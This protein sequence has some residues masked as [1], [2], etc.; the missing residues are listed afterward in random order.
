MPAELSATQERLWFLDQFADAPVSTVVWWARLGGA[1]DV[2]ALAGALGALVERHP[3]LRTVVVARDGRPVPVVSA[4]EAGALP[5]LDLS[6]S[7]EA[8]AVERA[9]REFAAEPFDLATGPLLRARLLRLGEDEHELLV[10]AHQIALDRAG[11]AGFGLALAE[12]FAGLPGGDGFAAFAAGERARLADPGLGDVTRSWRE[13][14]A[15]IPPL[16]LPTDRNRPSGAGYA[17]SLWTTAIDPELAEAVDAFAAAEGRSAGEVW[18]GAVQALL[19][20]YTG[21]E[22]LALGEAAGPDP[23]WS[24]TLGPVGNITVRRGLLGENA[25]FRALLDAEAAPPPLPFPTLV[26]ALDPPRDPSRSPIFQVLTGTHVTPDLSF[27]AARVT[28][29]GYG[30]SGASLYDLDWWLD[31]LGDARRLA[32][33]YRRDL[34]DEATVERMARHFLILLKAMLSGPDRA[35]AELPLLDAA[36]TRLVMEDFNATDVP[37]PDEVTVQELFEEQVL[38]SPDV[39]AVTYEGAHL[40]YAELNARANRI[41]HRLRAAGVGRGDF[42]GLCLERDLDFLP[43]V[44]GVLKSGG[45]YV[46]LDPAYPPER[47]DFMVADTGARYLITQER[48]LGVIPSPPPEIIVVDRDRAE[49]DACPD[50]DPDNVN[51]AGDL[52]YVVYTSGSTGRPKGVETIH[53]GVVGLVINTDILALDAETSYLQ[54]SPLSFDAST[55]EIFGPL[56]NG[57]RVVLLPSGVPTPARVARTVVE[58]GVNT[59]WLVAPLANLTIDTHLDRLHGL[60]QFMIGGDALSIPHV[61]KVRAAM[62]DVRLVNGYGPTEVTAFSVTLQI[63]QI[64]A[65]WPS[66]PIGR[67]M[68]N[69]TAYILDERMAPLPVGIW[70]ELYLGGPRVGLGYH[71]RPDLNAVHFLPDPFRPGP[72]SRIYRTGDRVRWLPDGT[73]QFH[74]RLDTQV[75]IDGLR[76]ELG[77][78]QSVIAGHES[79]GAVVVTA[80]AIGS[81]RT[82]VAYVVPAGPGAFDAAALRASLSR[83]LPSVMVPAHYI[84]LETIPLTPN[85]KVDYRAL[86]EPELGGER[87]F[88]APES[89]PEQVLAGIWRD[90]LGVERVGAGDNF[91]ALGGHS[92]RAVAMLAGLGQACGV[93][94]SVQD[95]FEAPVLAD[96]AARVEE[97]MIAALPDQ[98]LAELLTEVSGRPEN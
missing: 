3:V 66:V 30:H 36:E 98:E 69:T 58:Q 50:A 64:P 57:G 75:K 84:L 55:L 17:A 31:G 20:R 73:I 37:Y 7:S 26:E 51:E 12:A 10:G 25:G 89:F 62:P 49:I 67:P 5:L 61:R 59:L 21:Q 24:R 35:I 95:V 9:R 14:L 27:G 45:A 76:V 77:E 60:R 63:G 70:G 53:R 4:A 38:R 34:F 46:P 91:F 28:A 2:D 6:G 29:A 93:E 54:I 78:I 18:A 1:L 80:P 74:G 68:N 16:E 56:L 65:D 81:R 92:L 43:A 40:T 42:V 48:L 33:A 94:L 23:Q 88:V 22:L 85:N 82:L 96:L 86:P 79:V 47:L 52:T 97:R 15:G 87:E 71:H 19:H 83:H 39:R 90:I 72:E 11:L 8:G 44:L 41:A 32:I 13:H